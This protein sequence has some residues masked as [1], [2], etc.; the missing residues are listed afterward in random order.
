MCY[1]IVYYGKYSVDLS[2]WCIDE[3]PGMASEKFQKYKFKSTNII[4]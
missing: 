1:I 3:W 4:S 2:H